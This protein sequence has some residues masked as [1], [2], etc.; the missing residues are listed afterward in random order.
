MASLKQHILIIILRILLSFQKKVFA[1]SHEIIHIIF[2]SNSIFKY[3]SM[4][5]THR[6]HP[7]KQRETN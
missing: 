6:A 4:S 7:D 5:H 1:S 3:F 2:F